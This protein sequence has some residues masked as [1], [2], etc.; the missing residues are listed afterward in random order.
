MADIRARRSV[1][2]VVRARA[3]SRARWLLNHGLGGDA[4]LGDGHALTE[5]L[6]AALPESCVALTEL[7]S[8]GTPVGGAGIVAQLLTTAAR[9]EAGVPMRTLATQLLHRGADWCGPAQSDTSALHAAAALGDVAIARDLLARGADPNTR[10]AQGCT[11]FHLA[12]KL[13]IDLAVPLLRALIQSGASP[14]IAAASGETPLGLAL[15]RSEHEPA[16]WLNWSRWKLPH[17]PLRPSDLPA[18]AAIGDIEAVERMLAFGFPLDADDA[19]GATALIRA[20]GAGYA[21]LVVRLLEA[22]ADTKRAAHSGT[23][24]LAAA[25]S[26]RREA[27]VRTLLSHGVAADM[28]MPG[29][30][31]ALIL[32]GALGLPRLAEALLEAGA[33]VNAVDDHATTPL[34]AAAQFAFGSSDTA[35]ARALFDM[36]LNAGAKIGARNQAGQD[37]LVILLGA[38]AQPGAPCDG[39]HLAALAKLLLQHDAAVDVQ[40]QRGV[41]R[42]TPARC[43]DCSAAR[44]R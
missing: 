18:A 7:V 37:A 40:D 41:T 34:L 5:A 6:I 23:H 13:D 36:L 4:R 32:A 30:G 8:R 12:L 24:C 10:D 19:Q 17:R 39:E 29:G 27:V 21:G 38:N 16:Y 2:F 25:V 14:E 26:A 31:T 1:F 3:D 22:G 44:A 9:G 35:A 43:T 15:A 33:D 28:R 42:F 20:A 11:P